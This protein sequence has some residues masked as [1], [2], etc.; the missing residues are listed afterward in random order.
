MRF[1][2]FQTFPLVFGK[3]TTSVTFLQR[4][5]RALYKMSNQS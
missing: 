4:C 5:P 2:T 1:Q 3:L